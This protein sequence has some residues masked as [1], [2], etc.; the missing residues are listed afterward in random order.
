ML[1]LTEKQMLI[2]AIGKFVVDEV[3]T[4]VAPFI[5]RLAN[6]EKTIG[7]LPVPR[8]GNDGKDADMSAVAAM[9]ADSNRMLNGTLRTYVDEQMAAL[10][11]PVNGK[12][13]TNGKDADMPAIETMIATNHLHLIS[14]V[15][16]QIAALPKPEKGERG[17]KGD[18]GDPGEPGKDGEDGRDG[19]DGKSLSID[20]IREC[21]ADLVRKAFA[22]VPIPH[23]CVGGHID[24]RGHLYLRFSDGSDSDLGEVVG[25]D[26]KDCDIELVKSQVAAFLATIETPK[27]GK[28][29]RDGVDGVG[30]DDLEFDFDGERTATMKFVKGE[31]AKVL[32]MHFFTPLDRGI[33][34]PGE[35]E[36][37]DMVQRDGSTWIAERDTNGQP[38][39]PDSGWRLCTKRGRDGKD[40]KPGPEGPQGKPGRDGR[41][42]TQLGPDGRK[43]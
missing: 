40:G 26:G 17:E 23:N 33:W 39:L 5:L 43:W 12:D 38:G 1:A 21:L 14:Y 15:D 8:D 4:A 41:D 31:V 27:D 29:G 24:R 20:D 13:G 28:D 7:D 35:Y 2:N 37:A 32:N 11:V 22:D 36:R 16:E 30:F 9:I 19:A 18:K 34:K 6:V 10:P 42:L 25:R 3:Q